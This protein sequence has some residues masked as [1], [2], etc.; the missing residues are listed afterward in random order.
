MWSCCLQW[1]V[2][3]VVFVDF[4]MLFIFSYVNGGDICYDYAAYMDYMAHGVLCSKRPLNLI[5]HSRFFKRIFF[6]GYRFWR[7]RRFDLC[8]LNK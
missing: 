6:S 8:T 5:T 2:D 3:F 4:V 1:Q 7:Y